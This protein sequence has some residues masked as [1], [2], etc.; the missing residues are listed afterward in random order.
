VRETATRPIVAQLIEQIGYGSDGDVD[1]AEAIATRRKLTVDPWLRVKGVKN[2][3]GLGDCSIIEGGA[4][5][6]TAQVAG[7][8]G[9]YLGR[10]LSKA[11][12]PAREEG[13]IWQGDGRKIMHPFSFLSLGAMAY[14]GMLA[15]CHWATC[16]YSSI[17]LHLRKCLCKNIS[18]FLDLTILLFSDFISSY[19]RQR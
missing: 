19:A 11:L 4:L 18:S 15:A 8:Q 12:D 10:L 6:A 16:S 9:A 17:L 14:I 7:Q 5:P 2:V 3:F 1:A 13:P